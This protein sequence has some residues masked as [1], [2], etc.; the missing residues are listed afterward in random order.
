MPYTSGRVRLYYEVHGEGRPLVLIHANPFDHRLW[1][2]QIA[3]FSQLFTVVAV[4]IRGYGRSDK[5]EVPFTLRD[6]ADD[7]LAVCAQEKI[8]RAV[9]AGVS[10]GSG[11]AML[12]GL[13]QPDMVDALIL[14]GGS[15]RGGDVSRRIKGYTSPDLPA[16][17]MAHMRE[18]FAPGFFETT[19]GR[20]VQALFGATSRNLSGRCIAEIFRARGSC[21]M[22]GRLPDMKPA[23]LVING[24]HDG[25]M[26]GGVET[27]S[28]IPGAQHF[29]LPATGHACCIE[30]PH[31][32]DARML[33]FLRDGT[34]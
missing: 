6:M 15:S 31:T 12:I 21:D 2:Y 29:V 18:L 1:T 23:T 8:S 7:V 28:R 16:Y 4:D 30:D 34:I 13:D 20:W 26:K 11:I 9:F 17:H 22:T 10:V 27:A 24:E 5:P 3:S 25:S 19:S 14:V 32:F 33:Q